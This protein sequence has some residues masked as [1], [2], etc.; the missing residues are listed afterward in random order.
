MS[1]VVQ[2]KCTEVHKLKAILPVQDTGTQSNSDTN[3]IA[4]SLA[5]L[6]KSTALLRKYR[7]TFH[8][9]K[10]LPLILPSSTKRKATDLHINQNYLLQFI[11]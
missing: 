3:R 4:H 10:I 6:C 11:L 5:S 7:H 2:L 1:L 9:S 8:S